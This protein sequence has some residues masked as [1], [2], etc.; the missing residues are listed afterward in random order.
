MGTARKASFSIDLD[1]QFLC[2]GVLIR[3]TH[4]LL[5]DYEE[6]PY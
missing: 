3:K 1:K 5:F 2:E 4:L 6:G